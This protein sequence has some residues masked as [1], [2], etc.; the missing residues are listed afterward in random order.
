[1]IKKPKWTKKTIDKDGEK[2]VFSFL[3]TGNTQMPALQIV[4]CVIENKILMPTAHNG[5]NYFN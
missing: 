1:M 3:T 2:N 5:S 4:V